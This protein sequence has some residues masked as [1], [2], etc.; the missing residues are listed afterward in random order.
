MKNLLKVVMF[1]LLTIGFFAGFA[2]FGIPED[3]AGAAVFLASKE[4]SFITG[5]TINVNGGLFMS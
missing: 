4:A 5:Q 1:S 2:R 3:V